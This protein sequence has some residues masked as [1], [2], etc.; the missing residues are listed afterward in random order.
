MERK[1]ETRRRKERREGEKREMER[2]R[3][4]EGGGGGGGV[5]TNFVTGHLRRNVNLQNGRSGDGGPT[6]S[7]MIKSA[8][9]R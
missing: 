3:A 1:G 4:N 2:R 5:R 6:V 9:W 7:P 8:R